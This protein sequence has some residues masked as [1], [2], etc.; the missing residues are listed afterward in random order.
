MDRAF[1]LDFLRN[2]AANNH[3]AWMDENRADYHRARAIYTALVAEVLAGLQQFE[4]D[5]RG[6]TPTDV[7]F[8]INKNDRSQRD[9][10]PYKR[11]MGAGMKRGGRHAPVAGYFMAVQPGGHTWMGAG[12]WKPDTANLTRVRQEIH[13]NGPEFQALRE[14]P[15]LQHHFPTGLQGDRLQRPPRGYDQHTPDLEWLRLKEFTVAQPFPDTEVLRA[16]FAARVVTGLRAAQPLVRFLNQAL[17]D[18]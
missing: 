2:L 7:M 15:D 8:R 5:L 12:I 11:R 3:K 16:D 14:T 4:P 6:L 1:L 10:E 13:Y 9:P 17:L 18:G